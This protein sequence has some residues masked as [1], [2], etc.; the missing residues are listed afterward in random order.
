M[1]TTPYYRTDLTEAQWTL[2]LT[3]LPARKWRPGGPG[4]PPWDLR[5]GLNGILYLLKTGGQWR[6]LPREFG[7]GNTLYA[8]CKAWRQ[9]GVWAKLMEALRQGERR[10]QGRQAEPSAG[11]G[12][13]QSI[14][15]ATQATEVG[16]AGGKQVKG[17]KRPLVVDTLGLRIAVVVT[18]ANTDD[19]VGFRLRFTRYVVS[20]V[21]RLRKLWVAGG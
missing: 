14:K 18:A 6:M 7:Q 12:E 1:S 21:K 13:S 5:Q 8:Y 17:R 20:G 10:R 15:T 4:R 11:S 19:R 2:L 9:A 3:L 16:F